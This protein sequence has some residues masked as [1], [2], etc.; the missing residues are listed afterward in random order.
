MLSDDIAVIGANRE[1]WREG[2]VRQFVVFANCL[3]QFLERL[4]IIHTLTEEEVNHRTASVF[5]LQIIL[6]IHQL[7]Q[8]ISVIDWQVAGIGVE[9]MLDRRT[10][11]IGKVCSVREA[12][13][14]ELRQA[15]GRTLSWRCL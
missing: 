9:R 7:K 11:T 3:D 5:G 6:Q 15:V 1:A 8:I 12:G 13:L 4:W 14:V 10:Q 2:K